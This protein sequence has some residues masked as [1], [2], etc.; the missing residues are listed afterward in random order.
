MTKP[1]EFIKSTQN[2]VLLEDYSL[3]DV[4]WFMKDYAKQ[5]HKEK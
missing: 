5:Y 4:E 1:K 3:K 2:N